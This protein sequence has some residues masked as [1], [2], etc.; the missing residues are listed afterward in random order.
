VPVSVR[1]RVQTRGFEYNR[2]LSTAMF[3]VTDFR[4]LTT[5]TILVALAFLVAGYACWRLYT[6]LPWIRIAAAVHAQRGAVNCGDVLQSQGPDVAASAIHCAVTAHAEQ[7]PFRVTFHVWGTDEAGW[8]AL[9][10]D[11]QGNA[12]ETTYATG[13]VVDRNV[14]LRHRCGS[15]VTLKPTSAHP[16]GIPLL[17]CEPWPPQ[18]VE[19]DWLLW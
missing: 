4:P 15:P 14:L 13:A 6:R 3:Q 10:G 8:F 17:H 2:L 19:R 11:S 1:G 5:R 16:Y 12:I 18:S 7:R 9:I